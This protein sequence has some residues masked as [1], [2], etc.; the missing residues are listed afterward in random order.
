MLS[1][2][3]HP[4]TETFQTYLSNLDE[5]L[6]I[7][8]LTTPKT[9]SLDKVRDELL[10]KRLFIRE[11]LNMFKALPSDYRAEDKRRAEQEGVS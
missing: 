6:D 4:G 2:L 3:Q 5:A 7:M 8:V 11:L 9:S 10:A 1:W